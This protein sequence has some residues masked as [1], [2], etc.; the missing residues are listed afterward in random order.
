M[1]YFRKTPTTSP[2]VSIQTF[3]PHAKGLSGLYTILHPPLT[4]ISWKYVLSLYVLHVRGGF[5]SP[6]LPFARMTCWFTCMIFFIRPPSV[7]RDVRGMAHLVQ[8]LENILGYITC[9]F[10]S[11]FCVSSDIETYLLGLPSH[12]LRRTSSTILPRPT[13]A[14]PRVWS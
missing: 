10:S 1:S 2:F 5:L 13:I 14:S 9:R 3:A 4:S 12:R 7:V 11:A 8:S 6:L